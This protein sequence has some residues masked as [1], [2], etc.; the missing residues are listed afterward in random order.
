MLATCVLASCGPAI[1]ADFDSPEPAARNAAIVKAARNA[2]QQSVDEL[3]HLLR[4]DDPATR[5]LASETL[6]KLTGES[7]GYDPSS[8]ETQREL[9]IAKWEQ[10]LKDRR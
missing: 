3:V 9:A 8:N 10:W 6:E 5:L 4:S 7:Q 2:D 1:H